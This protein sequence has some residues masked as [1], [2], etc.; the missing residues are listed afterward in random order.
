[1]R[2]LGLDFG[3]TN[4]ALA[5]HDGSA[6]RILPVSG[7]ATW[8]T[9]L[10][11]AEGEEPL[12]GEPA[13]ER[14][15]HGGCRFVQSIKSHLA[16]P[17][18]DRTQ[19]LGRTYRLPEL[20]AV[21]L[22]KL[23]TA[24][25]FVF[26]DGRACFSDGAPIEQIVVGRP[27]RYVGAEAPEHDALAVAR[28][29]EAMR[30]AGL[31]SPTLELEP[32]AAA[33]HYESQLD[34]DELVLVADF[35]GGTS[36]FSL[37]EVG[38]ARLRAGPDHARFVHGHGGVGLAG[39]ALDAELVHHAV[40]PTL[41]RGSRYRLPGNGGTMEVP[42]W[43]YGKLRRWHHLSFLRSQRTLELLHHLRI[44]AE[45]PDKL[46]SL[47]H[48]VEDDLGLPLFRAVEGAKVRL[49]HAEE[50]ELSFVDGPIA[51]RAPVSRA[52]FEAWTEDVRGS[53]E[54]SLDALLTEA[55]A[56][57]ADVD[58]VF[59]TG[60]TSL[61]PSVVAAFERRF[62]V[63]KLRGRGGEQLT[64]VALGLAARMGSGGPDGDGPGATRAIA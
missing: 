11:F 64:S 26:R 41:G 54:A 9:V 7:R 44:Q 5:L 32:L 51:L 29:E 4:S 62:G 13:M 34:H 18:V 8:R 57:P 43:I 39:D 38:P 53:I 12:A 28:L 45:E 50:T 2:R 31:P 63:D 22:R 24:A 30:L 37:V 10:T 46:R 56:R 35:G 6:A 59:M 15:A 17:L 47:L 36:D 27:V 21:F 19:I 20:V 58:A 33:F 23:L 55:N 49:S 25:G 40:T 14:A 61:V 60:G 48:V 3:T 42:P 1:M 16:S 52:A